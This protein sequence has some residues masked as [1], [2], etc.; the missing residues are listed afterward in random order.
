MKPSLTLLMLTRL[1]Q[2]PLLFT[3]IMLAACR[4]TL[5]EDFASRPKIQEELWA[6]P[7]PLPVLA[8][9][10]RPVGDGPFPLVIMNHG[11]SLNADERVMFPTIEYLD[12]AFWFARRGYFVISPI[13]YAASSLD[14]K[15]RG[16]FG[17]VFAHVGSCDN[18]NFR[19]P[20]LAIATLNEW[21]IEYM[22]KKEQIA[23]GNVIVVGQSGGGWGSIAL[24]SR[25]PPSV[26]AIITF[27][28]GRGGRV[29]GKPNNNC[30]PDK[31]VAA[32]SEF[33]RTARAPM[34]WIYS[35]NDSYF[36]PELTKR[37]HD[38][39]AAA[40]GNAEYHLLPAFGNDGH[41]LIDSADAVPLWAPLVSQFLEKHF[42]G[43]AAQTEK[44]HPKPHPSRV[45]FP[46]NVQYSAWRK[47]C[48]RTSD[49][50]ATLCRTTSTGTEDSG[51]VVLRADLI[52]RA[53]GA[54]R[55]QLFVPLGLDLS[56]GV[57]VSID[58]GVPTQIPYNWCLTNI[59]IAAAPVSSTLIAEMG[60]GQML[61]IEQTD[62]NSSTVATSVPLYQFAS[63]HKS[64][65]ADT[66]D[67]QLDDN[68]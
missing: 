21:V 34:L 47:V 20:G 46:Q 63:A 32:T 61:K 26:R 57:K 16:L 68:D 5:A 12:A 28:A 62:F 49:G 42:P 22:S 56:A 51:E 58:Q 54:A 33:G 15:D 6:L 64:P 50:A 55:L 9:V 35:E 29:D 41:F 14:A 10:V 45:H 23:P 66:Y 48:F 18:P 17:A 3:A 52:E 67:F 59:C 30:A 24:A 65:P 44:L 1:L 13:R 31:L 53:D 27:A 38:A 19:G 37:M 25:N 60:S 7:F 11:I 2:V 8:Y 4:P 39:F 36:G 43:N 40:G